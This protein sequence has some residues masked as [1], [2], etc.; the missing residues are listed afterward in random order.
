MVQTS[1]HI[2]RSID[3]DDFLIEFRSDEIVKVTFKE[4]M[5]LDVPLQ[6]KLYELLAQICE[7]K[8]YGFI[9]DAKDN[10]IITKE[11]R[12]NATRL[13]KNSSS[14]ASAAIATSLPYRLIA[15]FYLKFNKPGIPFKI[16]KK[17]EEAIVWLSKQA[18]KNKK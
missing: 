4:N 6:E 1:I 8:K 16:F 11:A 17:E 12:E 3:T 9:F 14:F 13:E 10:V 18:K 2:I 15:N 5:V 7:G